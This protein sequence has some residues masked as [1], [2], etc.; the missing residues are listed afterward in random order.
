[1]QGEALV[2]RACTS[3]HALSFVTAVRRTPDDWIA[4]ITRMQTHGA[5]MTD[6]ERQ[7][8]AAYLVENFG[9]Q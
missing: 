7:A 4:L 8:V 3:C 6:A 9:R 5:R 2:N 1:M